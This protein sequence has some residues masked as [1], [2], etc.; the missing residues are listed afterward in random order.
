MSDPRA[1]TADGTPPKIA[2]FFNTFEVFA[3][4]KFLRYLTA[5]QKR[6]R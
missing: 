4:H 1:G 2:R 5:V 3:G 6:P